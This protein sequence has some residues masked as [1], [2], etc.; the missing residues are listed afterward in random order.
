[1][2]RL[3]IELPESFAFSVSIPVRI[4][5]LNY[6]GHVGNDTILS[7]LHEARVQFLLSRSYT[8]MNMEGVGLI[9]SDAAIEFKAELFH[10]EA[11]KAY[12]TAGDFGRVGFNLYYKL[13]KGSEET[14]VAAGRTGM[15]CFDYSRK[16]PVPLPSKAME[17]L[18]T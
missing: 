4:T 1:M 10:G 12:V 3:K 8:E 17:T 7:L 11:L 5:D 15:V 13:V 14:I 9:M 6:G 2:A 18:G 16:K